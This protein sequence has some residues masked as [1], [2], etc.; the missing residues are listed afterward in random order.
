MKTDK[1]D[2]LACARQMT[3]Y[4]DLRRMHPQFTVETH[5][6]IIARLIDLDCMLGAWEEMSELA[7]R[8]NGRPESFAWG[9]LNTCIDAFLVYKLVAVRPPAEHRRHYGKISETARKLIS[10]IQKDFELASW[11][12][13]ATRPHSHIVSDLTAFASRVGL[14]DRRA[15]DIGRAGLEYAVQRA[16]NLVSI[17]AELAE[18]SDFIREEGPLST[19]PSREDSHEIYFVRRVSGWLRETLGTP[20]HSV[21]ASAANAIFASNMD[22]ERVQRLANRNW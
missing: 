15:E 2:L 14:D 21:A 7:K 10:E 11:T 19:R 22:A 20:L 13:G 17:L 4:G 12:A 9:F 3:S 1:Y 8:F 18:Q 16:P 5:D 6:E